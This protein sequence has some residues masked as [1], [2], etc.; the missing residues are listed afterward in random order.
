MILAEITNFMC[1]QLLALCPSLNKWS[2]AIKHFLHY[3]VLVDSQLYES[4]QL[5]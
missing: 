1:G 4:L 3:L 5:L 2:D